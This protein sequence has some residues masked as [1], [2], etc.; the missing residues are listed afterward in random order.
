M[1]LR[2]FLFTRKM[3]KV[4]SGSIGQSHTPRFLAYSAVAW[5]GPL[6][7]VVVCVLLDRFSVF[8]IGYGG[9]RACW[10]AGDGTKTQR[11]AQLVVFAA[12]VGCTLV[13]NVFAFSQTI[14]AISVARQQTHRLNK[15]GHNN[16]N[17]V[18]IY[19]RLLSLMGFSWFFGFS[20]AYIHE[21]LMYP[22]VFFSTLQVLMESSKP[23]TTFSF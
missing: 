12:P 20:A 16:P 6:L 18:K 13:Y 19:I 1:F 10:I 8:D 23:S 11:N 17:M 7:L 5:G 15:A 14:W 2:C 22:F 21:A 4:Q 9:H 3:S